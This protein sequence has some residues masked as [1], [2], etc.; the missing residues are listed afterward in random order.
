MKR[1]AMLL[2]LKLPSNVHLSIVCG[3]NRK[4]QKKLSRRYAKN[5]NIHIWGYVENMSQLM[6]S[7]DLYLTKPGGISVTEAALK[8]LPMVF[9][10]AVAGCEE[11][12][13]LYF[14]RM[15][16]AKTAANS[17]ELANLCVYL[18]ENPQKLGHMHASLRK[19]EKN[20]AAHVI[21]TTMKHLSEEQYNE[22]DLA[23][24]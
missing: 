22:Q 2:S 9:I 20:N 19:Q 17:W 21:Y 8:D 16:G 10:D 24:C 23:C 3:T 13:K 11:Y 12:N 7:A 1:L 4:L 18:L 15:G 6:D 14:I 5:E